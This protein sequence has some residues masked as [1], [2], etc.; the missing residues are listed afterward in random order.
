MEKQIKG[1]KNKA[2][3]VGTGLIALSAAVSPQANAGT[4]TGNVTAEILTPIVVTVP[5]DL[6]FG[7]MT[8]ATA[9]GDTVT[10][11]T[12]GARTVA[13]TNVTL[14]A[15]AITPAA[16]SLNVA[17]AVGPT[18]RLQMT[19]TSFTVTDGAGNTM[20]VNN[21]QIA[22]AAGGTQEDV[23]LAASPETFPIGADLVVGAGQVAGSYTGTFSIS[24]NY[25]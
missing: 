25:Q 13:G 19:A 11:D 18:I 20:D 17:A 15:G 24:G 7:S 21:F 8:V 9:A 12:A 16:A 14:V 10:I 1:T 4:A 3:M 22:T 23:T 5:V 2:L 6:Q